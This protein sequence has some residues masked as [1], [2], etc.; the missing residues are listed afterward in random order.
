[1]RPIGCASPGCGRAGVTRGCCYRH[2]K[3]L[4]ARVR[5]GEVTWEQLEAR[6]ECR[7]ANPDALRRYRAG[8][9]LLAAGGQA[10]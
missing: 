9:G 5:A 3:R 7:P 10:S 4:A 8:R 2:Y 6:G 1:M